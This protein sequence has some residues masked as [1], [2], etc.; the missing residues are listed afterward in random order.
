MYKHMLV[1]IDDSPLAFEL[2]SDAVS[3]AKTLGAHIT[4][5]HSNTAEDSIYGDAAMLHAASPQTYLEQ[6]QWEARSVLARAEASARVVGVEFDSLSHQKHGS[7]AD[8]IIKA[9]EE[10][11]C[12]LVVMASHGRSTRL[13]MYLSSSSIAVLSQASVSLLQIVPGAGGDP[14]MRQA[15]G[16][17]EEEHRTIAAV[18]HGICQL[19]ADHTDGVPLKADERA[20][21]EAAFQ[22]LRDFTGRL[23]HPKEEQY[24]FAKLQIHN[25][26]INELLDELRLQH[27]QEG[28]LLA[29][30]QDTLDTTAIGDD[31]GP[32]SEKIKLYAKHLWNHM[33]TE[34]REVLPMARNLLTAADWAELND[35]FSGHTDPRFRSGDKK[36]MEA[37]YKRL[38]NLLPHEQQKR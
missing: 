17:I 4:F 5:F 27:V 13:S 21:I 1:P 28:K 35:A 9:A 3:L 37:L 15:L 2:V 30:A 7:I 22:F 26:E 32:L 20:I 24:L 6:Y 16:R 31:S 11:G 18:M 34:E 23:H 10:T 36:A 25:S 38:V 19:S 12:D 14:V 8:G 29:Q 33:A